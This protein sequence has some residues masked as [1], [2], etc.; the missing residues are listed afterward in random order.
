M[1]R[2]GLRFRGRPLPRWRLL[3]GILSAGVAGVLLLWVLLGFL[4]GFPPVPGASGPGGLRAVAAV[5]VAGLLVASLAFA[6]F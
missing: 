3:L 6:D 4:P 5:I 1:F 2:L